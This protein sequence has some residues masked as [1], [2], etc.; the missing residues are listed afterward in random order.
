MST[1]KVLSPTELTGHMMGV[2]NIAICTMVAAIEDTSR[3]RV[4]RTARNNPSQARL[5]QSMRRPGMTRRM[6]GDGIKEKMMDMGMKMLMV[7]SN[8]IRLRHNTRRICT[9]YGTLICL[10]IRLF[11][12]NASQ[13]SVMVDDRKPQKMNPSARNG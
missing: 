10:M 4:L 8:T 6:S 1:M 5:M 3:K 12:R 13:L 9:E 11:S 2:A 7:C